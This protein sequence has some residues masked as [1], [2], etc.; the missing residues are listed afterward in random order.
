ME[1]LV[2]KDKHIEYEIIRT[3]KKKE[4][5][6][7]SVDDN[8][9]YFT[10]PEYADDKTIKTVL[11]QRFYDLYYKIH[12]EERYTIHYKGKAYIAECLKRSRDEV[13]VEDEKITIKAMKVTSLYYRN[14]LYRFF[15]KT[16]EEELGKLMDG[17]K[18]DFEE[19]E[20]PKIIIKPIKG[21]L[22]YNYIDHIKISPVIAKF[23]I[24]Y[25]KVLL[26]HEIC[27]SIVRGHKKEFWDLLESKLPG[28]VALNKELNSIKYNDYL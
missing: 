11:S 8:I 26:Y 17:A 23:D 10:V 24:K 6:L 2:K 7:A 13:I 27:H 1:K 18:A 9:V 28:A 15:A 3:N 20:I 25:L 5:Y 4:Y 21:Y 22:G 16:I 14:V 19:I 12:P